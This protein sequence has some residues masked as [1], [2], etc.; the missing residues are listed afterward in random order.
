VSAPSLSCAAARALLDERLDRRLDGNEASALADHLAACEGCRA[1]A[2]ALARLHRNLGA[3]LGAAAA[4]PGPAFTERVVA[5]L[6]RA[7]GS[8]AAGPARRGAALARGLVAA[9][10]IAG[11]AALALLLFPP[12]ALASG[13]A[14]LPAVPLPGWGDLPP[15]PGALL[16]DLPPGVGPGDAIAALGGA[17]LALLLLRSRTGRP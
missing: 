7:P 14:A 9:T 10:G 12:E 13:L 2:A 16:A 15:S 8:A 1:E 3:V 6:D 4:D 11:L 17:V 5:A